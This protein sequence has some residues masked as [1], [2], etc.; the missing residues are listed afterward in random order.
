[1][2]GALAVYGV[3]IW[4]CVTKKHRAEVLKKW[5]VCMDR[6]FVPAKQQQQQ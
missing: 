2:F 4:K 6:N 5:M 3:L 1:M